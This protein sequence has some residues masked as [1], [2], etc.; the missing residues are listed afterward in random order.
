MAEADK[1]IAAQSAV[2]EEAKVTIA[3]LQS[4]LDAAKEVHTQ[5]VLR[6]QS[7]EKCPKPSMPTLAVAHKIEAVDLDLLA[8][9]QRAKLESLAGEIHGIFAEVSHRAAQKAEQQ[10]EEEA[11]ETHGTGAGASQLAAQKPVRQGGY[12]VGAGAK[13]DVAMAEAEPGP[14]HLGEEDVKRLLQQMAPDAEVDDAVVQKHLALCRAHRADLGG[15]R[16]DRRPSPY[17]Q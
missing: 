12:Y 6:A 7:E 3:S 9:E 8:E 14:E 10:E 1:I 17:E 2:R 15:R 13:G 16:A 4:E 5:A 11:G